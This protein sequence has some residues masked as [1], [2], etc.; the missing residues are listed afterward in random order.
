MGFTAVAARDYD[1]TL[2]R[3]RLHVVTGPERIA[4][5]TEEF[6]KCTTEVAEDAEAFVIR[7]LF[8]IDAAVPEF[9]DPRAVEDFSK[10]KCSILRRRSA[11]K[12]MKL[13]MNDASQEKPRN[14]F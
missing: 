9:E 10:L 13:A 8:Q 4:K 12:E 2:P 14:P 3:E 5:A 11:E 7:H 6:N 1:G